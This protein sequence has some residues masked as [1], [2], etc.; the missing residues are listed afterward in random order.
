V[1]KAAYHDVD[2]DNKGDRYRPS[3]GVDLQDSNDGT[4]KTAWNEAGEWLEYN[5]VVP[6][7]SAYQFLFRVASGDSGGIVQ[8]E[9]NGEDLTGDIDL[10]STGDYET[11]TTFEGPIVDLTGGEHT[12][13]LNVENGDYHMNWLELEPVPEPASLFTLLFGF[14][15]LFK[16]RSPPAE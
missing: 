3:E 16:R 9:L 10:P 8:L 7:N 4:Y 6:K 11:W 13:R 15:V 12:L 1:V 5:L 14:G 2:S